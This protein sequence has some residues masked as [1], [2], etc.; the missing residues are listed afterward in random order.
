MFKHLQLVLSAAVLAVAI[1]AAACSELDRKIDVPQSFT[2]LLDQAENTGTDF[3]MVVDKD[4]R[5]GD[6]E[7]HKD[8]IKN[9]AI[10]K[11]TFVV[12]SYSGVG[13]T[14]LTGNL[15]F[16]QKGNGSYKTIGSVSNANLQALSASGEEVPV[17]ISNE[18]VKNELKELIMQGNIISFKLEGSTSSNPLIARLKFKV[19]SNITVGL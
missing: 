12:E 18:S 19:Y 11:V 2:F 17:S 16:A 4:T 10:E 15:Q 7:K 3:A 6:I 14:T 8:K 13:G 5:D 9:S 1:A